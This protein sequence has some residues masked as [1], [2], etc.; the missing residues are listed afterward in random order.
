MLKSGLINFLLK[1]G[2]GSK[3]YFQYPNIVPQLK[4]KFKSQNLYYSNTN[5][6]MSNRGDG[7]SY[8][9]H[10]NMVDISPKTIEI[11]KIKSQAIGE[12]LR[13]KLKSYVDI[14]VGKIIENKIKNNLGR[15]VRVD[16]DSTVYDAIKVMN[17]KRVGATIVVDKNN[18]MTGIFSERDYLSK[19]DLRGLTP[20]ETLVKDIM[21]SKVI[22]VSG[23]SG[24]SKCLSIMT[25]RNIRHLPVLDN[26]RLIGM[27]S[28]GDIVKYIIS[29]Q[30]QELN[31][32]KSDILH[33]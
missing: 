27:L 33:D 14:Q 7:S 28:I 4:I 10:S 18:R 3:N 24:A 15:I 31:G 25:K 23:D 12:T 21:S 19:V 32:L 20:R 29:E 13:P 26:K 11:I 30:S 6:N 9:H 22:T 16:E 8:H 17:E 1:R 5:I 2:N